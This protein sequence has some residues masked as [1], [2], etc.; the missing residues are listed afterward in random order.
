M[1]GEG[2]VGREPPG[3]QEGSFWGEPPQRGDPGVPRRVCARG[4]EGKGG[5]SPFWGG[6]FAS[7]GRA[8]RNCRDC[9]GQK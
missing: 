3:L 7:A 9:G 8:Q 6:K 4:Q 5:G 1:C 2:G